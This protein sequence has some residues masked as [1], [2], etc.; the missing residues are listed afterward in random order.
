MGE[1]GWERDIFRTLYA[2]EFVILILTESNHTILQHDTF[3]II[4]LPIPSFIDMSSL[5]PACTVLTINLFRQ[6]HIESNG[7]HSSIPDHN[8]ACMVWLVANSS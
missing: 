2:L 8:H 7:V 3:E 1:W 4:L 6:C 5:G